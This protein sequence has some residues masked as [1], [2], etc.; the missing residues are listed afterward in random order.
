MDQ[1][2]AA[3]PCCGGRI[4]ENTVAAVADSDDEIRR[5]GGVFQS[6]RRGEIE[7]RSR[8]IYRH[9][10]VSNQAGNRQNLIAAEID[11]PGDLGRDWREVGD[12]PGRWVPPISERERGRGVLVWGAGKWAMGLNR[13]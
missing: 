8:G 9:S 7:G 3:I 4:K 12:D 13:G 11:A 5:P 10:S 6:G 2:R 1:K